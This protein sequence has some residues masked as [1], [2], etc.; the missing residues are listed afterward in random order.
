MR[1]IK[2]GLRKPPHIIVKRVLQE[3]RAELE[4]IALPRSVRKFTLSH[5]LKAVRQPSLTVLWDELAKRPFCSAMAGISSA[6]VN[7]DEII[8]R[9][10]KAMNKE[11]SLLGSG[12]ISLGDIIDWHKDYKTGKRWQNAYFRNIEYNNPDL[13]SDV[14]FPW[15]L[16][17]LQ[18]LIP[19]G[20]A[21]HL[22]KDEKY[23]VFAKTILTHWIENNPVGQS[24]NWACT[25]EAAMRIFTWSWFFHIFNASDAWQAEVF[26]IEFL[27]SLYWHAVFTE[28]FIEVSDVN[29]NHFTA[30]AS[31]L[32]VAG[33]FW[34][35]GKKPQRWLT[36]G[37]QYLETE[38][39]RQV[40]TDGV[41]FE[42]ST[43][44][45]RLVAEL[46]Y[47]AAKYR[48]QHGLT[49]SSVY[50][51]RLCKMGEFAQAYT[52]M[53][54]SVPLWGDADDARMLPF[55]F[56]SIN[57]HRYLPY[58]IGLLFNDDSLTAYTPGS[59]DE[60]VWWYGT[61]I[62]VSTQPNL[63]SEAR[64]FIDGGF[65][66]MRH[67]D[68]HV[69]IDCGEVGLAGRGG[70]GHNDC[71]SFSARL[72]GCD[73]ICDRGAYLYTASYEQ[74]NAFRATA[75]H[76]TPQIDNAEVN[77]FIAPHYLWNLHYDA[78]PEVLS[79]VAQENEWL[80]KGRHTGY[81]RL[82]QSVTPERTISYKPADHV[83]SINDQLLGSG[84][85]TVTIP[86]HLAV[87]VSI[88]QNGQSYFLHKGEDTFLLTWHS[89]H[90]WQVVVEPTTISPSYGV[91]IETCKLVWQIDAELPLDLE[92]QIMPWYVMDERE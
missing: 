8:N 16:S 2:R 54:G 79:W 74:R 48:M 28:R 29:G 51:Q 37:W 31:A 45:H 20:Q 21:Y 84:Q 81:Q 24:V 92:I 80:F 49:V 65:Y 78:K 70:H 38:I 11:V 42:C 75:S 76:N 68:D 50:Q 56:Q 3:S 85:H 59:I 39:V 14:K 43:A 7:A 35:T 66:I 61:Q 86:L 91:L 34:H 83:L 77:R 90:A 64:A 9:A 33:L 72:L 60:V 47:I 73:L 88:R 52:R 55:G 10:E 36:R 82:R 26:Q 30:D 89:K 62:D 44:Y 27:T 12:T 25:M 57:D 15:E 23:A 40:H 67:Q 13:P 1:K 19:V 87:G 5:L 58:L 17:R 4:R 18:W 6:E 32:V 46:F 71:L 41:D 22:T 63:T 53:D 69:F